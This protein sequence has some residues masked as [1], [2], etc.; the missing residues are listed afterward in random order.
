MHSVGL[1]CVKKSTA[2]AS[3]GQDRESQQACTGE[4][5]FGFLVLQEGI[6]PA[7]A[8]RT[9]GGQSKEAE[10]L[11]QGGMERVA[12][13]VNQKGVSSSLLGPNIKVYCSLSS[14]YCCSTLGT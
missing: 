4:Q 2:A 12:G 5:G 9:E 14:F 6:H 1:P 8:G 13:K 11:L 7:T 10:S 3:A